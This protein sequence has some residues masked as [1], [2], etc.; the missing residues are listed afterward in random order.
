[1]SLAHGA[2]KALDNRD[3]GVS[4]ARDMKTNNRIELARDDCG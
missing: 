4:H 1:M 3:K 2:V